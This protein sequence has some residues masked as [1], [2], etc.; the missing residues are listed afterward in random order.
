MVFLIGF[1]VLII[2][3]PF[4]FWRKSVERLSFQWFVAI[5]APVAIS[6]L[7]RYFSHIETHWYYILFFVA[8]FIA[9]QSIGQMLQSRV[10]SKVSG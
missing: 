7:L 6:I 4:G 2:N 5:H 10:T 9:G 1:I 8:I 3:I